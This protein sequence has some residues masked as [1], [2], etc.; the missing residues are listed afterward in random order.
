MGTG[1]I[2]AAESFLKLRRFAL[3]GVSRNPQDFSRGLL[4]ELLARG[5]DVVPVNPAAQEI[6][7]RRA[8]ARIAEVAP[9]VQ[10]A[11]LLLPPAQAEGAAREVLDAGVRH[12]WFHR[13]GGPGAG[14]PE[15][16]ALCQAMGVTP[17]TDLC[18]F[19]MLAGAGWFH[20]LH[21]HLR[22]KSVARAS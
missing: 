18:P 2:Q 20:R 19:M 22:K 4:R 3:V 7:G 1:T 5:Y 11:L 14:S 10:G 17:V 6:E 21:G 8:F 16:V 9:P 15:A 12:V 13:G